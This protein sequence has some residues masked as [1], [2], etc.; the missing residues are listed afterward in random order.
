MKTSAG[1]N[2]ICMISKQHAFGLILP[3]KMGK[4]LN[5]IL[6]SVGGIRTIKCFSP[7][8]GKL[9]LVKGVYTNS[10]HHIIAF[11]KRTG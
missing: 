8:V 10:D 4:G 5:R 1:G 2:I 6:F 9:G 3:A 11:W 7:T